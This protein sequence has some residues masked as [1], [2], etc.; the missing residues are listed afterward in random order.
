MSNS[1]T[2]STTKLYHCEAAPCFLTA[3]FPFKSLEN[4]CNC[5]IS[6]QYFY[7]ICYCSKRALIKEPDSSFRYRLSSPSSFDPLRSSFD[8]LRHLC[9]S[10]LKYLTCLWEALLLR[11]ASLTSSANSNVNYSRSSIFCCSGDSFAKDLSTS[12][13]TNT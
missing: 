13:C 5:E 11:S 6:R 8:L 7:S 9:A 12:F 4:N 1:Q 10:C 3:R 2:I